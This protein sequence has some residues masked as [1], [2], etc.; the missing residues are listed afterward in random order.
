MFKE[1]NFRT[2]HLSPQLQHGGLHFTTQ[3]DIYPIWKLEAFVA[4]KLEAK[5]EREIVW[6]LSEHGLVF[7]P[8]SALVKGLEVT[9]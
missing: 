3:H 2:T 5:L 4:F 8:L 1:W 7:P 9:D 6:W